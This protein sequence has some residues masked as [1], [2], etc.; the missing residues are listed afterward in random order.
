MPDFASARD[1]PRDLS[2]ARQGKCLSHYTR[3]VGLQILCKFAH[4][5]CACEWREQIDPGTMQHT[6]GFDERNLARRAVRLNNTHF[7]VSLKAGMN[8]P[9]VLVDFRWLIS[10]KLLIKVI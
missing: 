10:Q 8:E 5:L 4:H 1:R 6:R 7:E 2:Y 9:R 3:G